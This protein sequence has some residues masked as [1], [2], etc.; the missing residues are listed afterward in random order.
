MAKKA[1]APAP[2]EEPKTNLPAI[3]QTYDYGEDAGAGTEQVDVKDIAIPRLKLG[4]S[5]TPEVKDKIV[6]EG[7]LYHSITKEVVCAKGDKLKGIIVGI[8]TEYILWRDRK[9]GGGIM[10][11]A[12][13]VQTKNGY[14]YKW[15]KPNSTFTDKLDGRTAV[16]YKTA[17]YIDQDKLSEWGTQVPNDPESGPAATKHHHYLVCL[18][19][20]NFEV[21]AISLARTAEKKAKNLNAI[22]NAP[23][24]NG[25]VPPLFAKMYNLST[26]EE[27][28]GDNRYANWVFDG[29]GFIDPKSDTF[30][31]AKT[32]FDQFKTASYQVAMDDDAQNEARAGS[33]GTG[34]GKF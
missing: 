23:M 17:E 31:R 21:V 27:V 9:T 6:E 1:S 30:H 18:P 16:E 26:V 8:T 13:R 32:V 2:V 7:D 3:V 20:R 25:Q 28:S 19:E 12:K 34:D 15:D 5:M 29:A 10:A 14:R 24:S 11:R 22:I 33:K 4:Q